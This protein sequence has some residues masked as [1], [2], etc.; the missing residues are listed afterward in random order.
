MGIKRSLKQRILARAMD[1]RKVAN[2]FSDEYSDNF[3][4]AD[5]ADSSQ[6][7]SNYFSVHDLNGKLSLYLRLGQRGGDAP[8][9]V[10]FV[11]RDQDGNVFM[12]E[13]D[14]FPKGE[15]VPM[16]VKCVKAGKIL[17]FT[18]KGNV[19]AAVLTEDGYAPD[20]ASKDIPV[21]LEAEFDATTESFEFSRHMSTEPVARALSREKFT[22]K[23]RAAMQEHHQVHYEQAGTVTA[24]MSFGGKDIKIDR[25]PAFRDHSYGKRD[26]NYFDRY[27]WLVGLLNSGEFIHNSLIRYPAVTELQ[28]GFRK[29]DGKT[30]CIKNCTSMDDLP[31][32]GG[33]PERFA[34][35]VEYE[36]GLVRKIECELDFTVRFLFGG[37]TYIVNE[38][39]SNFFVDGQPAGRGITE[40]AFNVDKTRWTR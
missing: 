2:P 6:N 26:W 10:W 1:K 14:H 37:G 29:F 34:Y 4:L 31:V 28:A 11:Y 8:T 19:K 13:Q 9:E 40:F 32:T 35:E 5:N 24:Q 38:G 22:K 3:R 27:V 20:T 21:E 15:T 33:V 36:D 23:F 16:T 25:L 39:V 7:N 18:F 12:A 17:R 30:V